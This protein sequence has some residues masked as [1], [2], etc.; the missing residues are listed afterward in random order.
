MNP[1]AT[2]RRLTAVAVLTM[3]VGCASPSPSLVPSPSAIPTPSP[4][5]T[6]TP[7]PD[8]TFPLAVVT[9]LTNLKATITLD[10]LGTLASG[11]QLVVPCEVTLTEP[12]ITA[13]APCVAANQVAV[14]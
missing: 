14:D 10:E 2:V 6:A 12:A 13:T 1:M 3:F 7:I 8:V 11:G 5:P 4:S 9:G